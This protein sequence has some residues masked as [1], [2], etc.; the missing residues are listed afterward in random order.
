M[1]KHSKG[2]FA[3]DICNITAGSAAELKVLLC[4]GP[5]QGL[6]SSAPY[7]TQAQP[8]NAGWV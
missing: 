4:G 5:L 6:R 8:K 1:T 3:C 2:R 7:R